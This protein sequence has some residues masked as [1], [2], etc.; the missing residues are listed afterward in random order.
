SLVFVNGE[1]HRRHRRVINPAFHRSFPLDKIGGC[2]NTLLDIVQRRIDA[3]PSPSTPI[4]MGDLV[5]RLTVEL[6]GHILLDYDFEALTEKEGDLFVLFE[7]VLKDFFN[8]VF[9]LV[10]FLD[11]IGLRPAAHK[12]AAHLIDELMRVVDIKREQIA[13]LRAAGQFEEA[14]RR[15]DLLQLIVEANTALAGEEGNVKGPVLSDIE[16]RHNMFAL[17]FAGLD[18]T[19]SG[20]GASMFMLAKYPEIQERARREVLEV[21]GGEGATDGQ[22]T[23]PLQGDLRQM[24]YLEA[25]VREALRMYPPP[26]TVPDRVLTQEM[27]FDGH[28]LPVGTSV[29]V[30][31]RPVQ[32]DPVAWPE[33]TKFDPERFLDEEGHVRPRND[34]SFVLFGLG[35]RQ[36]IGMQMAFTEMK[37]T[38]AMMLK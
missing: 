27:E 15:M 18:N 5:R 1:E 13:Q 37:V 26:G 11:R 2:V 29:G 21:L 20:I 32:Y 31:I 34:G 3:S 23:T 17:Y 33:P 28:I 25:V 9:F 4:P 10:P 6:L 12:R 24:H 16:V 8:P 22:I 35:S 14:E 19:S 7:Q 38:L 30:N 36:C